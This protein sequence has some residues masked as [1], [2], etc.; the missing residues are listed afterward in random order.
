MHEQMQLMSC[1]WA[2]HRGVGSQQGLGGLKARGCKETKQARG[3]E[4][5]LRP[6]VQGEQSSGRSPVE[7]RRFCAPSPPSALQKPD[8]GLMCVSVCVHFV[9]VYVSVHLY[10]CVYAFVR[11]IVLCVSICT[12]GVSVLYL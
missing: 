6:A 10:V 8:K 2:E 4:G 9:C 5:K 7:G 1:D 11:V 3:P 12:L